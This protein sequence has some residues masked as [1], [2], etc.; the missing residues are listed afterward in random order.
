MGRCVKPHAG[1]HVTTLLVAGLLTSVVAW[2]GLR[3]VLGA[4]NVT[5]P[6]WIG[7]VVMVFLGGGL[8]VAGWQVKQV[9]DGAA[10]RSLSP[11]RRRSTVI[12]AMSVERRRGTNDECRRSHHHKK[13]HHFKFSGHAS[14]RQPSAI[15]GD[16]RKP[17]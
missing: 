1:V 5:D 4:A 8:L 3:L 14:R 11:L 9:R 13:A 6:T 2:I 17:G 12:R 10:E 16:N 15:L 7:V